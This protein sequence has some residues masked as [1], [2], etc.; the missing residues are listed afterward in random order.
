MAN[1]GTIRLTGT[2]T[3]QATGPKELYAEWDLAAAVV[4]VQTVALASGDN[5]ITVPTGATVI[6]FSPPT[7]NVEVLKIKGN[8]AREDMQEAGRMADVDIVVNHKPRQ[9]DRVHVRGWGRHHQRRRRG[10]WL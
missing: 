1:T 4:D 2:V 3:G 10:C 8:A 5:T 9:A 6:L 7:T